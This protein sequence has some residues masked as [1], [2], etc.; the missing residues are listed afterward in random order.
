MSCL[1]VRREQEPGAEEPIVLA[2]RYGSQKLAAVLT[3]YRFK[4]DGRPFAPVLPT[5]GVEVEERLVD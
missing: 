2:L 4:A 5:D 3:A 1:P